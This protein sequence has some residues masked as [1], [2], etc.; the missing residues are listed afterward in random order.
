MVYT[1]GFLSILFFGALSSGAGYVSLTIADDFFETVKLERLTKGWVSVLFWFLVLWL[2][3]VVLAAIFFVYDQ[4]KYGRIEPL[5]NL[6]WWAFISVTTVGFGDIYIAHDTILLSDMFYV[7]LL[8]L[9]GF[10]FMTNFLLK[11]SETVMD[12]VQ[13]TGMTDDESLNF[14]LK[15]SRTRGMNFDTEEK[16]DKINDEL[17]V[18]SGWESDNKETKLTGPITTEEENI[19]LNEEINGERKE[20]N[21]QEEM[22]GRTIIFTSRY[23]RKQRKHSIAH[24]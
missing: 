14:L 7:P 22:K 12:T 19:V 9:L 13:K 15:Q 1:L 2:Y 24:F 16:N 23:E 20:L 11:F 5:P 17:M 8:L 6:I 3:I 18:E 10:V 21:D 4:Y